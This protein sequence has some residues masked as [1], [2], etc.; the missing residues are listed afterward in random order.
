MRWLLKIVA[1]LSS[2]IFR[3]PPANYTLQYVEVIQ[4]HHKRTPYVSNT[5]F[6][7]DVEW[8][9]DGSGPTFGVAT[10]VSYLQIN[11]QVHLTTTSRSD[12]DVSSPVQWQAFTDSSN[13]WTTTVGP[14]FVDSTYV[15]QR[16]SS[17][18]HKP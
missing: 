17:L 11:L 13:P 1:L 3:I 16:F 2:F 14:G 9:C 15:L 8:T 12:D 7:E 18:G 6:K 4:R 5:F 10:Y